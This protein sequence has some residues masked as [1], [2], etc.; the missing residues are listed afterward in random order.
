MKQITRN[1]VKELDSNNVLAYIL[2]DGEFNANE[3]AKSSDNRLCY[4]DFD[5]FIFEHDLQNLAYIILKNSDSLTGSTTL[6]VIG[7]LTEP[8]EYE[9]Q[10][11]VKAIIEEMQELTFAPHEISGNDVQVFSDLLTDNIERLIEALG[12]NDMSLS[13]DSKNKPQELTLKTQ[14]QDLHAL[15]HSMF[16]EDIHEVP[17]FTDGTIITAKDLADMNIN[18]LDS[19]AELIGFGLEE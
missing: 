19:I 6:E 12:L 2:K 15:N 5:E 14:I 8:Q 3:G 7:E 16:K 10:E 4:S 17:R 1:E 18:T 13:A 11:T 9:P